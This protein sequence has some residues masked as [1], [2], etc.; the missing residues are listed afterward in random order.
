[1]YRAVYLAALVLACWAAP[2]VAAP[3]NT[4][5]D[6]VVRVQSGP[7]LCAGALVDSAGR[8]A[9]AYHCVSSGRAPRVTTRDG[10]EVDA[11]ILAT[12][13]RE[14]LAV[15]EAPELAGRPGLPLREE[16]PALGEAVWALGHPFG[17][18]AQRGLFAGVLLWSASAGVVS[19][20]GARVIQVDAALNPGS[21]GG[22]LVDSAGRLV[23][24]VSRKLQGEGVGF[25][26]PA[27]QLGALLRSPTRRPGGGDLGAGPH[28]VLPS[29]LGGAPALGGWAEATLRDRV[30]LRADVAAPLGARWTALALG[31]ASWLSGSASL[32]A[33]ARVGRGP[34]SVALDLGGGAVVL[35][36]V[37]A[38]I[39]ERA[40]FAAPTP[41]QVLPAGV[42]RL[43]FGG[44]ALRVQVAPL[45]GGV[46]VGWG[47]ELERPGTVGVW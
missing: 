19:A 47:L 2:V 28:L 6:A 4:W 43:S 15:L 25:A 12:N 1:M 33:R 31:E 37:E 17:S 9:T 26:A 40:V 20:V 22:P 8:V 36:G 35:S 29:G 21:S 7:A 3:V 44:V 32:S 23:G 34:W 24:V 11:R 5:L 13:P 18:E 41:A 16:A 42:A 39:G 30:V 10:L 27:A 45:E 46:L 38:V 14:D